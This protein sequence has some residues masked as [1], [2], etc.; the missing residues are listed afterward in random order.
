VKTKQEY[1]PSTPVLGGKASRSVFG[2]VTVVYGSV[3]TD[4]FHLQAVPFA[5]IAKTVSFA[6]T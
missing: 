6:G 3:G 1:R 2:R 4:A 5:G